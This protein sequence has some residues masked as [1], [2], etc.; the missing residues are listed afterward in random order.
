MQDVFRGRVT[1]LRIFDKKFN[2]IETA[3]FLDGYT[4]EDKAI[5]YGLTNGVAKYIE[6]FDASESLEQNIIEQF[7]PVG[8]YYYG[9]SCR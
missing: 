3:E 2:Y 6:Q 4:N 9:R 5:C 1:E 8:G 7:Y